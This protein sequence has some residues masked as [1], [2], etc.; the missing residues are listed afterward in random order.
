VTDAPKDCSLLAGKTCARPFI[1]IA[2]RCKPKH[3]DVHRQRL[4]VHLMNLAILSCQISAMQIKHMFACLLLLSSTLVSTGATADLNDR[5]ASALGQS[6][7]A[8][9]ES[10][11]ESDQRF[12]ALF[13]AASLSLTQAIAI[14]ERLHAGSRTAAI[15]FDISGPPA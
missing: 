15:T 4:Q 5:S 7:P 14:A 6:A 10:N 2:K 9:Q 1:Q 13:R 11:P 8:H 12:L 3:R